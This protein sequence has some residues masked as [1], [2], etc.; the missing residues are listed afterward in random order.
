MGLMDEALDFLQQGLESAQA[1]GKRE[2][3]AK[4]RHQVTNQLIVTNNFSLQLR[5]KYGSQNIMFVKQFDFTGYSEWKEITK[6]KTFPID[7]KF[8]VS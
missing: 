5:I 6:N 4:I 8:I 1:S 3:E 7:K 2:D